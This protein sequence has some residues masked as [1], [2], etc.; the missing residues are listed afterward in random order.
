MLGL[1][2]QLDQALGDVQALR[3]SPSTDVLC[4]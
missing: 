3:I 1:Q 4:I 2:A